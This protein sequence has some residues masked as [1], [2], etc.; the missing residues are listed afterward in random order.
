MK[1]LSLR[2]VLI[3]A[4]AILAIVLAA[5]V[6]V[7]PLDQPFGPVAIA[8]LTAVVLVYL[9]RGARR[10]ARSAAANAR[11]RGRYRRGWRPMSGVSPAT[12][13]YPLG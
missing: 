6:L 3:L 7:G 13:V 8:V 2:R 9:I 12:E 4:G 1:S 11:A 5:V 10:A